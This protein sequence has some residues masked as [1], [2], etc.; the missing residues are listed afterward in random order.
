M[1]G[2]SNPLDDLPLVVTATQDVRSPLP[3]RAPGCCNER[4][5]ISRTPRHRRSDEREALRLFGL[6]IPAVFVSVHTPQRSKVVIRPFGQKPERPAE[7]RRGDAQR[8]DRVPD[9][10][11]AVS[12]GAFTVLPRL[13]PLNR[14][15]RD[16]KTFLTS[17]ECLPLVDGHDRALLDGMFA[18]R[19]VLDAPVVNDVGLGG[20]KVAAGRIDAQRPARLSIG[21][22]GGQPHRVTKE[23][24]DRVVV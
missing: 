21:F 20:V 12:E 3:R 16:E 17:E 9:V 22:P 8:G 2:F 4:S 24:G 19:V 11:L 18:G 14:C 23:P 13:A 5:A 10:V 7:E 6:G 1:R 15:E